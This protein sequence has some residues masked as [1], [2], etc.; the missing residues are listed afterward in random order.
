MSCEE[1]LTLGKRL[2]D[3]E[4]DPEIMWHIRRRSERIRAFFAGAEDR[5]LKAL[6]LRQH[7]IS[8]SE[9]SRILKVS[10]RSVNRYLDKLGGR[11]AHLP[12]RQNQTSSELYRKGA[13][14]VINP[15]T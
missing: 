15:N 11:Y 6:E 7:G 10:R 12:P 4:P 14:I 8:I 3:D 9:I 13:G 2:G 5:R 1:I